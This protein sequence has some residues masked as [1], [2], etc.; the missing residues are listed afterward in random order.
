[1]RASS[2]RCGL[3]GCEAII[4]CGAKRKE[5]FSRKVHTRLASP[6]G[7]TV[8]AGGKSWCHLVVLFAGGQLTVLYG[9]SSTK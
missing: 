5:I 6:L 1:M 4:Y 7:L 8:L 9:T 3:C 2:W